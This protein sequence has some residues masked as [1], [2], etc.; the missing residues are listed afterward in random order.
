MVEEVA[1]SLLTRHHSLPSNLK[2]IF[3]ITDSDSETQK[4]V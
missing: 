4:M 2:S 3:K 1:A